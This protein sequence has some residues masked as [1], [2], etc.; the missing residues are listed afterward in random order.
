MA[1][2]GHNFVLVGKELTLERH[3][4]V[5]N[6]SIVVLSLLGGGL[7]LF[8]AD[9]LPH[10]FEFIA[11]G[12]LGVIEGPVS[13]KSRGGDESLGKLRRLRYLLLLA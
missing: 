4:K 11:I 6:R 7:V 2:S 1:F 5:I 10:F 3:C 9:L 12:H 13:P 8:L